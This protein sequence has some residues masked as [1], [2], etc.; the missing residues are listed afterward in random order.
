MSNVDPLTNHGTLLFT[1]AVTKDLHRQISKPTLTPSLKGGEWC[2]LQKHRPFPCT[3]QERFDKPLSSSCHVFIDQVP[4]RQD[5]RNFRTHRK[6]FKTPYPTT[7]AANPEELAALS[8]T[9]DHLRRKEQA[10]IFGAVSVPDGVRINQ[11][12]LDKRPAWNRE[13]K[14]EYFHFMFCVFYFLLLFQR[15]A[16]S[17]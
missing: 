3:Y 7:A 16:V 15:Y 10:E 8:A 6:S 13:L 17:N 1:E 4:S 9:L 14:V 11:G 5:T 2:G 12:E